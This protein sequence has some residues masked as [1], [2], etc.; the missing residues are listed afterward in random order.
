MGCP[1]NAAPLVASPD[2]TLKRLRGKQS[3]TQWQKQQMN[4]AALRTKWPAHP[5]LHR[6]LSHFGGVSVEQWIS[7]QGFL[8][9][10]DLHAMT[11]RWSNIRRL[12]QRL[13]AHNLHANS[14]ILHVFDSVQQ[15]RWQCARCHATGYLTWRT[16]W[17]RQECR[18]VQWHFEHAQETLRSE[19]ADALLALDGLSTLLR[20][21]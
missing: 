16:S 14:R 3:L 12:A 9:W 11:V 2:A 21:W 8:G 19:H 6:T 15:Q 10:R 1:L 18:D 13:I 7:E 4:H 5:A 17:C 20:A